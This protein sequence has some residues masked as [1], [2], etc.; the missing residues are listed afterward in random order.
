V[1][2]SSWVAMG[3]FGLGCS[4]NGPFQITFVSFQA[5]I[6]FKTFTACLVSVCAS[7]ALTAVLFQY[8]QMKP[9]F[10]HLTL[11]TVCFGCSV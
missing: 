9:R 10:H 3:S 11:I 2:E 6:F 8:P 7:T 4:L 5:Y 1:T